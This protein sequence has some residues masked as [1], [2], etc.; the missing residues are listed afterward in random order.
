MKKLRLVM[1][2]FAVI[3]LISCN[4]RGTKQ[5]NNFE[6]DTVAT[7][8]DKEIIG[9]WYIRKVIIND[10]LYACPS[11]I[12]PGIRQYITFNENGTVDVKTNCNGIGGN[13]TLKGDSLTIKGLSWTEMACDNMDVERLL[14]QILPRICVC[15]I[16][17]DSILLLETTIPCESIRLRKAFE[18]K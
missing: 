14:K 11:E 4:G 5:S 17:N 15:K 1:A 10:S 8:S 16:E 12:T 6:T 13:Y 18:K 9:Q 7:V 3:T 2:A